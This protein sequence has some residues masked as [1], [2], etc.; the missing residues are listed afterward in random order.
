M[1]NHIR[2]EFLDKH[3]DKFNIL[4]KILIG[5]LS[6]EEILENRLQQDIRILD[7]K[8]KKVGE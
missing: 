1:I 5:V 2:R 7:V 4:I 8:L 6:Y 3:G